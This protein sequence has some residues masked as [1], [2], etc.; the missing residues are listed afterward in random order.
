M[1]IRIFLNQK[2]V[3]WWALENT[4]FKFVVSIKDGNFLSSRFLKEG[5]GSMKRVS[6]FFN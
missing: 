2:S 1:N 4:E 5:L 6:S 3:Q